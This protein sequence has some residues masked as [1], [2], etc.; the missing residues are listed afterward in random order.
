MHASTMISF[1]NVSKSY[2]FSGGLKPIVTNLTLDFPS[3]KNVAIVGRNGA[4]KST[5][6]RIISGALPPDRGQ[7]IRKGRISWPMGFAGGLHPALTG[8]QNARFIA[9]IYGLNTEETVHFVDD[10]SELGGFLD[11]PL[12]TYSSG[13][14][15]RLSFAIS[16]AARFDCYL[17][18]EITEVGDAVFREKCRRAFHE[19]MKTAQRIVVAHS[20]P[21]LRSLCNSGLVLIDGVARFFED[22][23]EALELYRASLKR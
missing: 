18:D 7:I 1:R 20:E 5:L 6:L 11:M 3:D 14:K 16:L 17:I 13:M 9:R 19:H 21:T 12:N 10:F 23:E 8:R 2:R 4:G 22:L 15:A